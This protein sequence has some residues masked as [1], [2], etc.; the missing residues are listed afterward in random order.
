M[1]KNEGATIVS[2]IKAFEYQKANPNPNVI[3]ADMMWT[4]DRLDLKLGDKT[5]ELHYLGLNHGVGMTTFVIPDQKVNFL[6]FTS[7]LLQSKGVN[8]LWQV[9]KSS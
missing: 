3:L 4:G 1:F 8:C 9:I 6:C 5:V 2:H 7:T